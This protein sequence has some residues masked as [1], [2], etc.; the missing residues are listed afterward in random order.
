MTKNGEKTM[1]YSPP[2]STGNA[3]VTGFSNVGSGAGGAGKN[4]DK[5]LY[6]V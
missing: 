2:G 3:G 1:V 5:S 4:G 6:T